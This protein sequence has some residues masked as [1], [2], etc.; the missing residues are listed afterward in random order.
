MS[1]TAPDQNLGN[2]RWRHLFHPAK[3][4]HTESKCT[5]RTP[6]IRSQL[7]AAWKISRSSRA[8][9]IDSRTYLVP[10]KNSIATAED[11]GHAFSSKTG[12]FDHGLSCV[13]N[14][15]SGHLT[16]Q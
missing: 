4:G 10:H 9:L 2:R 7:A 13:R 6:V 8:R 16:G 1:A 14:G 12:A 11:H 5:Y 3:P 15:A